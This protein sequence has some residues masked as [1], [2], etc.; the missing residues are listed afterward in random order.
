M[1]DTV[2]CAGNSQ[3]PT[4]WYETDLQGDK[5]SQISNV[6]RL[7]CVW[8]GWGKEQPCLPGPSEKGSERK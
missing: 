4:V 5:C 7:V 3:G 6:P 8:E 1:P 2:P